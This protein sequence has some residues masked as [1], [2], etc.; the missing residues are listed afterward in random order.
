MVDKEVLRRGVARL[1]EE[2]ELEK[3]LLEVEKHKEEMPV[4]SNEAG[5]KKS[6]YPE[7]RIPHY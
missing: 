6:R 7:G 5:R 3:F 1:A 2:V 4:V